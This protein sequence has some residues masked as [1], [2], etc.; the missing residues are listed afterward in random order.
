M[1]EIYL[2]FM[3]NGLQPSELAKD[4]N[5]P[6]EIHAE[7]G[8]IATKGRYKGQPSPYGSAIYDIKDPE[9]NLTQLVEDTIAK[10]FEWIKVLRDYKLDKIT[11]G[12]N[13]FGLS[14]YELNLSNSSLADLHFIGVELAIYSASNKIEP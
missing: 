2:R 10:L 1:A 5:V 4:L 7:A 9:K 3:A 6:L 8:V 13:T 14:D 12:I 11:I